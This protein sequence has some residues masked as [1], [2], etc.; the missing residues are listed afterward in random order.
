[1]WI[2]YY[3]LAWLKVAGD[4]STLE[5]TNIYV[6]VFVK[7]IFYLKKIYNKHVFIPEAYLQEDIY[8]IYLFT[9]DI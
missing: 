2:K 4:L 6:F 9:P 5:H 1:M 7:Y 3:W 8:S